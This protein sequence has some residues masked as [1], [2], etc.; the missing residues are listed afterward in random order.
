MAN[1][2]GGLS[3]CM[4]GDEDIIGTT[5]KKNVKSRLLAA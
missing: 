1:H 3:L 5:K 2:A 4:F